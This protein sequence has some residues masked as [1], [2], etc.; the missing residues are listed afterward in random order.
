MGIEGDEDAVAG[1][2]SE[3][4]DLL[5]HCTPAGVPARIVHHRRNLSA[6]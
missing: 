2:N 4:A 3:V 5:P 1:A 6:E